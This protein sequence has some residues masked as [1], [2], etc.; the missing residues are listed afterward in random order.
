MKK[1]TSLM[2]MLL[3]AVTAWAQS[4]LR[5]S[6]GLLATQTN[7]Q[8]SWTSPKITKAD[9][10]KLRV[11]FMA[12]SNNEKPAGFP[13]VAIAEFYLYDK[14]GDAVTL[15][16]AN[17]SSNATQDGEG[18]MSSICDGFTTKQDGQGDYDWYWHSQWSGTPSPYGEH[19][20]EID[21]ANVPEGTNLSEFS[22]GWV[23][24]RAQASPADVIIATGATTEE[25]V[26]NTNNAMLPKVSTDIV[27]VYTIKNVRSNK[28]LTYSE[29]HAKPQQNS[30]VTN[31]GYWY[32]TEGTDGKVVMRNVA[33]GK[34]LGTNF[35]M[36]NEGEWFI[37]GSPYRYKGLV[38]SKTSDITQDNCIDDQGSQTTIGS[39]SHTAGDNQG[40]SWYI[41]EASF[42]VA[43]LPLQSMKIASIGEA[44]TE[45]AEG[46]YILNN[47]G[48]N[49][50]VSQEGNNWKMRGTDQVA[51]GD[52][53]REKAGYLFKITKNGEYYNVLSGNGKYFKLGRNTASTSATPVNIDITV[54][55]GNN[56]CLFD[57]DHGYAA[58]GQEVGNAFVGWATSVP[59][60]AGGN[61]SYR[62]LPVE[63]VDISNIEML[64]LP[65]TEAIAN[66][67]ALYENVNIGEGLGLYTAPADF[68]TQFA[69]IVAFHNAIDENTTAAEVEAKIA[70]LEA[71]VASFKLNA[72]VAGKYYTFSNGGYYITSKVNEG[73]RIAC[74]ETKDATAIYYFDGQHLL[75]YSTGLYFGL[76]QSD[77]TFE[78]VGSSD[79]STI[80]F[81]AVNGGTANVLN[82]CSG[83]RWLHRTDAYINRCSNNTC[84]ALHEWTIEEVEALPVSI[85][86]AG[87][88]T[89]FAPV[90]V[91]V[92]SGV[93][94]YTVAIDGDKAALSDIESGVIPANTG[95]VLAGAEG[96]YNF[97][98]TTAAAFE[99]ENALRGTAAATYISDEAYV[100][101]YINVAEEGQPE[102]KEVGFYTATMN[103]Q[104]T[105]KNNSHKAY[106]PKPADSGAAYYSFRFGEGTTGIE[107]VK[108]ENGEVKVI[109]DLT[110]RRIEAITAPGIYIVGGKKVLVK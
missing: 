39:W 38:I 67:Q 16:E 92:P 21:L 103:Q 24:R 97:A 15:T 56:F 3:C 73:G 90:A 110:G 104:D 100:L 23:T 25:L 69:A 55:S 11:T 14:N 86:S 50:Y 52:L 99:G 31:E 1:I 8:Y 6:E 98:I 2:L 42:D 106:L 20:L 63:L 60:N 18:K 61:D 54:I 83:G 34:V 75:A 101:G 46:W 5:V 10:T 33:S 95:V 64:K 79:I 4:S 105:W 87:Y 41:E 26:K 49:G 37:S 35:E 94:A 102:K 29:E 44:V 53:A 36:S 70:E 12:T 66:A 74:S 65:L 17:F 62:L 72:L 47:A 108:G 91:T 71:L 19:Y 45:L 59:A 109:Y 32:F 40:T 80:T 77:W 78:A 27:T 107:D 88:A 28:Y 22:F 82:I 48:R 84:G 57:K 7:T 93:T 58:D 85:T 89:F 51:A 43:M 13:C 9:A 81:A 96:T 76:N 68:E 30:N